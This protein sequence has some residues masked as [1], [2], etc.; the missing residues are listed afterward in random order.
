MNNLEFFI[1][2]LGFIFYLFFSIWQIYILNKNFSKIFLF[3]HILAKVHHFI[4]ASKKEQYFFSKHITVN[5]YFMISL[6]IWALIVY[7][8]YFFIKNKEAKNQIIT[9]LTLILDS[10]LVLNFYLF[11]NNLDIINILERLI[12]VG[13]K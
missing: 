12:K 13:G 9:F 7:K 5:I 6:V 4:I 11:I 8:I 2:F 1:V 3:Y 10:I